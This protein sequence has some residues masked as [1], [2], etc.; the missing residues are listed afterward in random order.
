MTSE[1]IERLAGQE[2]SL[3]RRYG[4]RLRVDKVTDDGRYALCS[5]CQVEQSFF[6]PLLPD[7]TLVTLA[8]RAFMT[9]NTFGLKTLISVVPKG[10]LTAFPA[11]DPLDPFHLRNALDTAAREQVRLSLTRPSRSSGIDK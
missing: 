9:L 1:L 3:L 5:A 4:V 10:P 11:L 2:R 6:R 7:I 8:E